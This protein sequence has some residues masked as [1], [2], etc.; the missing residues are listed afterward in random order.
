MFDLVAVL[1]AL[2][3]LMYLAYRGFTLLIL[4]PAMA[5]LAALVTGGLPI[6]GAYTQIFMSNTGSFIVSFFPLFML[7]AIFGKLMDDTGSAKSLARTV[8]DKLGPQRAIVSVVLCCAVLTY[9]GVS[10][11]VVAFA[12]FP[13]AAALF[14][15]AGI[16]KRL[17]PGA[18][19][20]GAFT[21]TMSAL[22]GT[23]AIQN[24]IPMPFL[25]TTAFAAPGLGIITG[26]VMLVLGVAWLN[27][28]AAR[29]RAAGEGYG[30]HAD[31]TPK[32]DV[33]MREHAQSEGFDIIELPEQSA[34]EPARNEN[35]PPFWLALLPIVVVI[36][37][38][39]AFVQFALPLMD[40]GF[41]ADPLFGATT[42]ESVRGVWAVIVALFFAIVLLIAGNW[43]RL[44]DLRTS[45]DKG[46][47]ASVL[48]IFNTA[49]L[50]GFGAVIA[51]LPVFSTISDAVM[52]IGGDNPLVSVALAVTVLS[53]M[54]GSASGGMSIA[55]DALGPTFVD[56]A[57]ATGVSLD[58]MHRVTAVAS[59]ALDALPHN[60]AVITLLTV[61][62]ISHRDAYGDIFVVA[63]AIPML[64]L[65]VLIVL[66]SLFGSF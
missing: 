38:N 42:L 4:A 36:V 40:T 14:R 24:A 21:F 20:L 17:M 47:D 35:L 19:A 27:R 56:L 63:C 8:S 51:A 57:A 31:N 2:V 39:F 44:A 16:P 37:T 3:L 62:K 48:P 25:G 6:L 23:P 61:C 10:A 53:A 43:R 7:G 50:V 15:A 46:A 33:V 12:I 58:A 55:L 26:L 41:L 22:P 30:A 9:G 60:G 59:G 13:V 1:V 29:A 64:S 54:T 52:A 18:L 28:R 34:R 66:A 45:L 49:S 32:T 5:L 65:I 11:F